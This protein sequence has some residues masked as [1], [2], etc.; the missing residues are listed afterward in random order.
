MERFLQ[1]LFDGLSIG[2]VY[3]LFA[4]G[5][6]IVYRGTGHLNFAQGEMA[7]FCTYV[8]YQL[9]EWGIP[10]VPA[11]AAGMLVGFAL[12]ATTEVALVRPVSKRSPFAVFIVTIGL[13]QLL[14]WLCGAIWGDRVLP[15][16]GAGSE[17]TS[18][19]ALFPSAD[20]DFVR[21]LGAEWRYR[22]LGVLA[23]AV[24][25]TFVLFF[26]F[27]R[28]RLGLAMRA[29]AGNRESSKLVGISTG[30]VLMISWGLAAA[31][32]AL[33]GVVY[34]GINQS[35]SVT[36]MF[37]VFVYSSAA[38]T[39][40]G[41]DSPG[42]AVV[43]GLIIGV[44]ENMAAGYQPVWVGQ[45]LKLGVAFAVILGVLLIRPSGL[46]GTAKVERV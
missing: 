22:Y 45:E 32:G 10:I 46:F 11:L 29:V 25:L 23:L 30:R 13:F 19:P 21:I 26:V 20:T 27:N 8:V 42:G 34:G 36:M 40:G 15:N 39:L 43:G 6:V 4:L 44:V 7:L 41:L 3:A 35:I 5:L 17:Q 18:F 14:N 31:I 38:A 12:G 33:G 2:S 1:Y 9:G 37:T 16:P 24:L 28:T